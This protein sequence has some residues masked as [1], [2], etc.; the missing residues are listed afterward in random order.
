VNYPRGTIRLAVM[1]ADNPIATKDS[2]ARPNDHDTPQAA[3]SAM[4]VFERKIVW[5]T[6]I[7]IAVATITAAIFYVQ[8][9]IMSEQT[10]ILASQ[11]ESSTAGALFSDMN[12]RKQLSI[13]QQQAKTAENS[14][15][16]IQKQTRNAERAWITIDNP[17]A[18]T[19][20]ENQP[21]TSKVKFVNVGNTVAR[22]IRF[23]A[24]VEFV[25]NGNGPKFD[26]RWDHTRATAGLLLKNEPVEL[27]A[28]RFKHQRSVAIDG[29][30]VLP[31]AHDEYQAFID[32]KD[33]IAVYAKVRYTDIFGTTHWTKRCGWFGNVPPG[34]TRYFT[35]EKC[36]SYG[37]VDNNN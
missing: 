32:G 37:N 17:A 6:L 26:Y 21:I 2:D 5:L 3:K 28:I 27:E 23:D 30:V 7:A 4:S 13:A 14:V 12:T 35:A 25:K 16:A 31:F 22:S 8:L 24:I 19:T 18:V 11:S 9:R 34:V 29:S 33:Y 1:P 10:Q 20:A 36:A 15:D